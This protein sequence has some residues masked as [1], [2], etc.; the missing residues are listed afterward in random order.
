MKANQIVIDK[1]VSVDMEKLREEFDSLVETIEIMND[2][3]LVKGITRSIDDV[4]SGRVSTLDS[5]DELDSKIWKNKPF[6]GHSL[7]SSE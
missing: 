4:R 2:K 1:Q 5:V 3:E 7:E 6:A